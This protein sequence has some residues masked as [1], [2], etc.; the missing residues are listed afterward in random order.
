MEHLRLEATAAL[1]GPRTELPN[2]LVSALIARL[3]P[4]QVEARAEHTTFHLFRSIAESPVR[5]SA[6]NMTSSH[7]PSAPCAASA[8]TELSEPLP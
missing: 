8:L 7:A 6:A 4:P 2:I 5:P 3:R 1:T